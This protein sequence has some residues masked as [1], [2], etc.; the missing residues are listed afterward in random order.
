MKILTLVGARPQF[1]KAAPLSFAIRQAG[2]TEFLLHTG[3]HY[4]YGMSQVF[5]EEL[6]IPEAD[7]NL[8]VRSGTHG[9]QTGR[10]L[11]RIETVLITEEPDW[12]L[13]FGDTN[14]TLAGSLAAVKLHIPLAHVE[15]GL[16][17]YNRQMPEEHNR[18]LTDHCADLLF[19]PTQTA[20]DNLAKEGLTRGVHLVGDP[21]FDAVRIFSL[22]A[23]QRSTI[24]QYLGLDRG[25]YLLATVHRAHNTDD[26]EN[27][28]AILSAL[29]SLEE[30]VVFPL[31]PRT[32]Q[33][34]HEF[35]LANLF[36]QNLRCIEP[37]GY[38]DML[39]LEQNARCIL[40]DSGGVQKEAYFFAVPCLTLRSET[41]W[42][43]TVTS[44]WNILVGTDTSRIKE[45]VHQPFPTQN[46]PPL[47]FGDG[48]A[49]ENIIKL[50]ERHD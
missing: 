39:Q 27:L 12:V 32:Q 40:T 11:A 44:G 31:H 36:T 26:P 17:S 1:I 18:V 48:H 21:M 43:E 47:L 42:T 3:Q 37:V 2:H 10:M 45:A 38:L 50:L 9:Q 35:D 6:S 20:V 41:E 13:V 4:D 15:A 16:R 23:Q 29:A 7:L 34:I 24:L 22:R 46:P 14:S 49:A 28:R 25:S 30:Q 33:K 5:F 19:C 8:D